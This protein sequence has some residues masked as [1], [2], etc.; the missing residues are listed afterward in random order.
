[1]KQYCHSLSKVPILLAAE[2]KTKK[3]NAKL[4]FFENNYRFNTEMALLKKQRWE[5]RI[6]FL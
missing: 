4:L 6:V 5:K 1:M 3:N 2:M